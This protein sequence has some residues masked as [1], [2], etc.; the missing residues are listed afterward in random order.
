MMQNFI[1]HVL[2]VNTDHSGTYGDTA[3]YYGTVEQQG[4]IDF[5]YAYVIVDQRGIDTTRNLQFHN[6][7]QF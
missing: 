5:A 6:E 1:K 4:S 2:G 7:S 3:V